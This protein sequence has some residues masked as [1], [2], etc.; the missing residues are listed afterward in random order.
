M[1]T[2]ITSVVISE[3]LNTALALSSCLFPM[4]RA[5]T[6][7]SPIVKSELTEVAS[8]IIGSTIPNTASSVFPMYFPISAESTLFPNGSKMPLMAF[9]IKSARKE[10]VR[11]VVFC[12]IVC[13][14]PIAFQICSIH[15]WILCRM[16]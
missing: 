12:V 5:A 6:G 1:T 3:M 4:C 2:E 9:A 16:S 11:E 13:V 14:L 10:R 7:I 8:M 15:R